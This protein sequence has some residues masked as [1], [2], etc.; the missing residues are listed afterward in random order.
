MAMASRGWWRAAGSV[1]L[2]LGLWPATAASAEVVEANLEV[3]G[4][5]DLGNSGPYG[6][7][8]FV[9]T[10]EIVAAGGGPA[11]AQGCP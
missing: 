10:T 2:G 6:D 5:N 1:V 7:V 11:A 3:F 4:H 8:A 9:G